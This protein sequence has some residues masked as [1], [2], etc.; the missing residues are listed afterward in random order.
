VCPERTGPAIAEA[1]GDDRWRELDVT[2]IAGGK[3]NLTF[4]LTSPAGSVVLR[5]PPTGEVLPS[6]HDMGREA[7]VQRALAGTAVPVPRVILEDRTGELLGVPCYVM[8]KVDGHVV[9]DV[10]P[11][12]YAPTPA[13]RTAMADALIDVLADLHRIDP[14]SVGLADYGRPAGFMA[15]QLRRWRGQW[16]ASKTHELPALDELGARLAD[17]APD[18]QRSTIVHGDFRLDN[19]LLDHRDPARVRAVLDWE[20]STLGDPM[21]DLGMLLFYWREP[22][23]PEPLLTPAIT[24]DEGFPGRRCTRKPGRP[25]GGG[26]GAARA[27]PRPAGSRPG[28]R[29]RGIRA[30]GCAGCRRRRGTRLPPGP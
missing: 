22:G 21:A 7:R 2:M 18:A 15:R 14:A 10:L 19:C 24:R 6:A 23:E 3:S 20:L 8:E 4:E 1:L 30:G 13:D 17:A 12:G 27:R 16:D 26:A 5:R 25:A 29:S 9:R 11:R 28:P